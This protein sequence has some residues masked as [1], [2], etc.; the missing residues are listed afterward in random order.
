MKAS[1]LIPF[2]LLL[3]AGCSTAPKAPSAGTA[4]VNTKE[5]QVEKEEQGGRKLKE[6][7]QAVAEDNKGEAKKKQVCKNIKPTGSHFTQ[8]VCRTRE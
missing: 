1:L 8:R 6:E 5:V 3:L 7:Q 4:M 2:G